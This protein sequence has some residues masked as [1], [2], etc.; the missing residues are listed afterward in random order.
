MLTSRKKL[1]DRPWVLF[2]LEFLIVMLSVLLALGLDSWRANKAEFELAD[3][4]LQNFEREILTNLAEVQEAYNHHVKLF[5][6][7][8]NGRRGIS[9]RAATIENSAW[10]V[11]KSTGSIAIIDFEIV[12][13]ASKIHELQRK[14]QRIEESSADI[15]YQG[16]FQFLGLDIENISDE[17][18]KSALSNLVRRLM[19][20]ER[21]LLEAY[22][23]YLE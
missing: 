11:A 3:K 12:E 22:E 2:S 7:I 16:N 10:E 5:D 17:I 23:K 6:E 15:I 9:M 1:K 21:E 19:L 8:M 14:Y 18:F 13:L 4:V 20:A